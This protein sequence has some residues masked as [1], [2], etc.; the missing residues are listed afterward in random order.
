M[1]IQAFARTLIF[2]AVVIAIWCASIGDQALIVSGCV[3]LALTSIAIYCYCFLHPNKFRQTWHATCKLFKYTGRRIADGAYWLLE[4]WAKTLTKF[5]NWCCKTDFD[6]EVP[7][8][9]DHIKH[10][11][12]RHTDDTP[13]RRIARWMD[14]LGIFACITFALIGAVCIYY[15]AIVTSIVTCVICIHGFCIYATFYNDA[16]LGTGDLDEFF[17]TSPT[18]GAFCTYLQIII[19]GAMTFIVIIFTIARHFSTAVVTEPEPG[20]IFG[21]LVN[22]RFNQFSLPVPDN[23]IISLSPIVI[24]TIIGVLITIFCYAQVCTSIHELV[25]PEQADVE[26]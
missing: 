5:I 11:A 23:F 22:L 2:F 10:S 26:N 25:H 12:D 6:E 24:A 15:D 21:P 17:P 3:K 16:T 18:V 7:A 8:A 4:F 1:K 9:R 20:F 19:M 13:I 14:A